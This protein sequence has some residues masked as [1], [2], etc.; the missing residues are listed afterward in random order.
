MFVASLLRQK[1]TEIIHVSPDARITEVLD[2]LG[3]RGIGAVLV[4][5]TAN[6]LVGILSERDIVRSLMRDGARTLDMTAAQLMTRELTTA[7][8]RTTVVEAMRMMTNGR[9]RHIPVLDEGRLVGLI[10]IGDV[11]K[12]RISE[13]EEDVGSLRAFI[14]GAA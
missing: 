7:S 6:Q 2:V 5:D 9:F 3:Q 11:V 14:S 12:G 10:S 13:Q 4:M 1:G 8:L